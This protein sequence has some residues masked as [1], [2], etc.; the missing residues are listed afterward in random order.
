MNNI[1]QLL[2][3]QSKIFS[4]FIGLSVFS[5]FILMIRMKL[6][7]SYYYLFLVWN[8]FLAFI[9]FA[10]STY[11]S[12][13]QKLNN[14]TIIIISMVWLLF[15]PNAPYIVTDLFHLQYSHPNRIW[16]DVLTISA[17]AVT[18]MYFF[19]QSLLTME[20]IFKKKFGKTTSTYITPLLIVLVAFG[21]YLGR[22]LR[23]NSWEI[24][25]QP[26]SIFESITSIIFNPKT[27]YNA[28]LFTALFALFLAVFYYAFKSNNKKAS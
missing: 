3:D 8:L 23:F 13:Q 4:T 12:F 10:I 2:F 18:G 16:L 6:T 1:K 21:V 7:G 11:L 24:I 14:I 26:L 27:H 17:F 22:Y 25:S 19:Y 5:L 9:P 28:L 15:L 20:T